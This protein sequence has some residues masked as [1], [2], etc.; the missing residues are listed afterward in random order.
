VCK[1]YYK[2]IEQMIEIENR[3]IDLTL[4]S[5]QRVKVRLRLMV[6]WYSHS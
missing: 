5:G 3:Q 4:N 1:M 2:A 6:F